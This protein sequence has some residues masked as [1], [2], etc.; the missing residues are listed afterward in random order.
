[1]D[2]YNF[3]VEMMVVNNDGTVLI[4][5]N[6]NELL[7]VEEGEDPVSPNMTPVDHKYYNFLQRG[8]TAA[9]SQ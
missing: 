1:M 7:K 2:D 4:H 9:N 6:A 5:E 8:I 3:P